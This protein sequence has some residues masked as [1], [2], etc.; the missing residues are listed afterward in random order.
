ML[1]FIFSE[2]DETI[3]DV[4]LKITRRQS[5]IMLRL[6]NYVKTYIGPVLNAV[7]YCAELDV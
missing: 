5:Q 3:G 7:E 6:V 1:L 2:L 4:L